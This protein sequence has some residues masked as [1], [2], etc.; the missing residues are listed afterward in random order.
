MFCTEVDCVKCHETFY[1]YWSHPSTWYWIA[2]RKR[3][4]IRECH[5]FEELNNGQEEFKELN[6]GQEEFEEL[7]NEQEEFKELNNGH[8]EFEELN[9]GQEGFEGDKY[10]KKTT[11]NHLNIFW[12]T[13]ERL[14]ICTCLKI[15]ER[16]EL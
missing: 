16:P 1:C 4:V 10:D 7:N 12:T 8:E 15:W 11:V 14:Y 9:N 13:L 3:T 2:I 6:N 5:R